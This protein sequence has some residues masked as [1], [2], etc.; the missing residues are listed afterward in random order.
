SINDIGTRRYIAHTLALPTHV[1]GVTDD[2]DVDFV[3][4]IEFGDSAIR[5]AE[6]ARRAGR[7][8]DAVNELWPLIA[9]L[10]A[11]VADGHIE[12][13]ILLLLGRARAALG[14][15]LGTILPEE[16]LAA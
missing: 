10:E 12:R 11:R 6:I 14:V 3:A 4:M 8:V 7:A 16:R 1:F 5:L 9:R 15:S 13:D 2:G